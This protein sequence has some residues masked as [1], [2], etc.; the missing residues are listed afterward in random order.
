MAM[1][2][3]IKRMQHEA[4]IEAR[5]Y[6]AHPKLRPYIKKRRM[7]EQK[8]ASGVHRKRRVKRSPP[9]PRDPV[10]DALFAGVEA[11]CKQLGNGPIERA[12]QAAVEAVRSHAPVI[13]DARKDPPG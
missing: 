2:R 1:G 11:Y 10:I 3:A 6:W 7:A 12:S 8:L 13:V 5:R 9:H 4:G